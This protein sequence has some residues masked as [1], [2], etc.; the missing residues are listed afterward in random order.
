MSN[1]STSS[2]KG[3]PWLQGIVDTL[4][5]ARFLRQTTIPHR[6][7]LVVILLDSALETGCRAYL[8]H[9]RN[10]KL[11]VAHRHRDNL[12]KLVRSK[13]TDIDSEV[14]DGL[15]FY[16]E[17]IR[18]DLYHDSANK[19]LTDSAILDYE[20]AV[21]FVLDRAFAVKIGELVEEAIG[22]LA[23]AAGSEPLTSTIASIDWSR[24]PSRTDRV[25]AGVSVLSPR[26]VDELNTFFKK[27]G[28]PLRLTP[29]EFGNIL[30]RNSGSK[31]FFYYD[32]D[33]KRWALS[34]SGR[35]KLATL[36][37]EN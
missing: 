32:K 11:D 23:P 21:Y 16:Y 26:K 20:E 13:L 36:Q 30:A 28:V 14:W 9:E 24:L 31:N 10:I 7:R 34:A 22:G 18:N 3:K 29:Q 15:D 6:N 17:E 1:G 35:F 5:G 12:M 4:I 19:T 8:R 27:E 2:G 25:L 33:E 37:K